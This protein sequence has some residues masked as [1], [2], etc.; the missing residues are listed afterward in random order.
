MTPGAAA[1]TTSWS[2]TRQ[3]GRPS[4]R[5]ASRSPPGISATADSVVRITTGSI[6]TASAS[7]AANAEK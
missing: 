2:D 5:P 1:G 6:R 3:R 7:E 4:A